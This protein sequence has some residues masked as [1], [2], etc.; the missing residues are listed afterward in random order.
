M[1]P[2]IIHLIWMQG[3]SGL[4]TQYLGYCQ[5]WERKHLKWDVKMW[6]KETLPTLQ[7]AWVLDIDNPVIQ[8]D[9]ARFELVKQFGGVYV[10]CD[11]FCLQSLDSLIA[12]YDAFISKRSRDM[13]ASSSFGATPEH[14]WLVDLVNEIEASKD[15]LITPGEI[16]GPIERATR[17]HPNVTRLPYTVLEAGQAQPGAYATHHKSGAWRNDFQKLVETPAKRP[18]DKLKRTNKWRGSERGQTR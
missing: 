12:K 18:K 3:V 9:V 13:L 4:P 2:K 1:I 7:N 15:K 11:M 5:S 8:A 10:D 16:R 17:R 6:S 14:P